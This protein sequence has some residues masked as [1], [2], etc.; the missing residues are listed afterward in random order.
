MS[1]S[2]K[3][4]TQQVADYLM[5]LH[6]GVA[7]T[8]DSV[9]RIRVNDKTA[10]VGRVSEN[11]TISINQPAL[12]GGNKKEGGLRGLVEVLLGGPT[13]TL[14][15]RLIAKLG[16]GA[17]G[18]PGFRGL[19]SLFFTG[20]GAEGAAGFMWGSNSPY[21][22]PIDVTVRRAP[23]GFYPTKAWVP[24]RPGSYDA[25]VRTY[26]SI[27]FAD[28]AGSPGGRTIRIKN[29]TSSGFITEGDGYERP[30]TAQAVPMDPG[31]ETNSPTP[32][33]FSIT[34]P[35]GYKMV[36]W[37]AGRPVAC[38]PSS[39]FGEPA[40]KI[41]ISVVDNTWV[42]FD[43][44]IPAAEKLIGLAFSQSDNLTM[45]LSRVGP[46]APSVNGPAKW[47]LLDQNGTVINSGPVSGGL[48]A[49]A[50]GYSNATSYE[51]GFRAA[52]LE[53]GGSALW[54]IDGAGTRTLYWWAIS[55]TGSLEL[56]GAM[57]N[58]IAESSA[59][60]YP[61]VWAISGGAYMVAGGNYPPPGGLYRPYAGAFLR[62]QTVYDYANANPAHII[63]ECLTNDDWG[64]GLQP[65]MI[66][67]DSFIAAADTLYDEA[68]G[69]SMMW[70]TQSSI[71]Q[72]V[73]DILEHIDGTYGID[74]QTG[75][76][77]LSLVR[78][79]YST[80]DLH[81]LTPD[82]CRI[83]RF[84]RKSL[85]ETIN[86]VTV[87]WTNPENEQEQTVTVHDLANY[88][89]QGVLNS[90]SSNYYGVRSAELATR[91][92]IRDLTRAA[93][94]LASFEA[95]VDRSAWDFKPG[96]IVSLTYPEY[97]IS[98]LPVRVTSVNYGRPGAS[99][100]QVTMLEDVFN[101]PAG[102]Y[103]EVSS[104]LTEDV[105]EPAGLLD[106]FQGG[107]TPYYF[108]AQKL[109][110]AD[111]AAMEPIE[112][113][114]MLFGASAQPLTTLNL[115]TPETDALG[116][117]LYPYQ[118]SITV[119]GRATLSAP[120]ACEAVTASAT[121]QSFVGNVSPAAALFAWIG[122]GD[123][124]TSELALISA[125][126]AGLS[127]KRGVLDTNPKVWPAGTP[128]WFFG[129]RDITS[130]DSGLVGQTEQYKV[131]PQTMSGGP[132]EAIVPVSSVLLDA[133]Q[134]RPYRPA[135]VQINGQYWPTVGFGPLV[136]TF[137][138]RNRLTEEPVVRDWNATDVT[139]EAGQTVTATLRRVDTNA[140]LA[141]TTG[142]TGTS[143]TFD[144]SYTGAVSLTLTS[145]RDGLSSF[146]PYTHTFVLTVPR[147]TESG[148]QRITEDG[149]ARTLED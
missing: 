27:D 58:A 123:P 94:P 44:G 82:N 8:V 109:G 78:G 85:T 59:F 20:G 25:V 103:V 134:H 124:A 127:L 2:S 9:E 72:F 13:Q 131:I 144:P 104:S 147:V 41:R 115:H 149:E 102:A 56:G 83:T 46:T 50:V 60:Y 62:D 69:L 47:Y 32:P 42:R 139:P 135:N 33:F 22:K 12:F 132:D 1:K 89:A 7:H 98:A 63:Y 3:K 71:E 21:M 15:S 28:W 86:E 74:P 110:A 138:R 5:S 100:V 118:G 126:G 38:K 79:G 119:S 53:P 6:V 81:T 146:Q 140:V 48:D 77:Y 129:S 36:G 61:S 76:I 73:N 80:G 93:T 52:S 66:D 49:Y 137:A 96:D 84:Q 45:A 35:S 141:E 11:G 136:I 40:L 31:S 70:S 24:E 112:A 65:T 148:E 17:D 95:D 114:A 68:L 16:Q 117:I 106:Y 64:L 75:K 18:T 37:V 143:V 39:A 120:L 128:I 87:T 34:P 23:K 99:K 54:S 55:P 91:L 130:P 88:A 121:I 29:A 51:L 101:T 67:T 97:G 133:R 14:P 4:P 90:S 105:S 10:Y 125:V 113:Y 108:V 107:S 57:S 145:V 122:T 30:F 142:I 43:S 19:T 111:A 92:A 26:E 116:N